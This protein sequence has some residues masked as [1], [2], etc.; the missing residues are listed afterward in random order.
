MTCGEVEVLAINVTPS[1]IYKTKQTMTLL[2]TSA[3]EWLKARLEEAAI[4]RYVTLH[5]FDNK[6]LTCESFS[7]KMDIPTILSTL[8]PDLGP[9]EAMYK[10]LHQNPGL[11]LQEHLAAEIA[12]KHLQALEG[13]EVKTGIGGTGLIGIFKNGEGKTVLLR[14]DTDALPVNE[15]TGLEY[16]SRK[17]ETDIE[18]N[19]EKPV[20]HACGHDMHVGLSN[21]KSYENWILK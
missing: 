21:P 5:Y 17:K 1:R 19:V 10:N 13:F 15:L 11:S 3:E 8:R 9:Y 14:A 20:M 4:S 18:D 2:N 7:P 16:A 6:P 12:A